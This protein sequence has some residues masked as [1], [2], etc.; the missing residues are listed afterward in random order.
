M[1]SERD[2]KVFYGNQSIRR[3]FDFECS[4]QNCFWNLSSTSGLSQICK[5]RNVWKLPSS[6]SRNTLIRSSEKSSCSLKTSFW[7]K[8]CPTNSKMVMKI[9]RSE[10]S[11]GTELEVSR[12]FSFYRFE[13]NQ[14]C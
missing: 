6:F 12:H 3:F 1:A 13:T 7:K 4:F 5:M 10:Y 14:R 9:L 8:N 2:H 11:L